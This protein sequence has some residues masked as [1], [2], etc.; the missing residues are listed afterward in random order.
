MSFTHG[1][2]AANQ[3]SSLAASDRTWIDYPATTGYAANALNQYTTVGAARPTYDGNGNL[4]FDGIF[5]FGYDAEN[6]L[7]SASKTGTTASYIFDARGRRTTKTVNGATTAF[8]TD[9]DNREVLEYNAS[10]IITRWYAYGLGPNDV[11]AQTGGGTNTRTTP[12]PDLLGSIVGQ[13]DASSGSLTR[14]GYKPYGSSSAAPGQL[15][16]TG[17]RIDA[18]LSGLH[19][20]RAREY[21]PA[22]GRFLQVDPAGYRESSH[23]YAYVGNDPLNATDSSG[24]CPTCLLGGLLNVGI[25]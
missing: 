7:T 25:G 13:L 21:S 19:Y 3:R 6:H 9:A 24:N 14:F 12:I 15:A 5:T 4:T 22:W 20:Y 10:G 11:L 16:F 1:Y 8:V 2:N 23:L 18:E 17:Q